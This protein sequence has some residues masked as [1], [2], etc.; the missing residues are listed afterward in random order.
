MMAENN[1]TEG[2]TRHFVTPPKLERPIGKKAIQTICLLFYFVILAATCP[3]AH[4]KSQPPYFDY[5][6]GGGPFVLA[7]RS[8]GP[9]L[10]LT[11][12]PLV[13]SNLSKG[14]VIIDAGTSWTNVWANEAFYYFDYEMIESHLSLTYGINK[15]WMV[16]ISFI[17]RNYFGGAMD[18]FI[19]E[20]HDL[21]GIDQDG[22]GNAPTGKSK[23]L[24]LDGNGNT[25]ADLGAANVFNNSSAQ[26]MSSLILTPG[27]KLLPAINLS[28]VVQYG[29]ETPF[30]DNADPLDISIGIGLSKRWASRWYSYHTIRYTRFSQTNI[31]HLTFKNSS[32]SSTNTLSWQ[33]HPGL[34]FLLQYMYHEDVIKN[35]NSLSDPSHEIGL[36]FKWQIRKS[37]VIEFSIIENIL[38]YA[39][40]PDFGVHL[41]YSHRFH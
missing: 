22:R 40:S 38:D 13:P 32:L 34:S 37:G 8:P 41:A 27:T 21:F 28:A 16:G 31:P 29:L 18:D 9:S 20:F 7:S 5:N 33:K 35:L 2:L 4:G 36:G 14:Q 6:F 23:L 24:L 12:P 19:I 26:L 10:R 30:D 39:N 1:S 3:T 15:R 11:E 17:K 25:V